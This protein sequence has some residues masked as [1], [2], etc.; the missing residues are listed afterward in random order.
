[1][2]QVGGGSTIGPKPPK[3]PKPKPQPQYGSEA[4]YTGS[5]QQQAAGNNR[6]TQ[7]RGTS[8]P[9]QSRTST[10]TE[11]SIAP[12]QQRRAGNNRVQRTVR[13]QS[14]PFNFYAVRGATQVATGKSMVGKPGYKNLNR[15]NTPTEARAAGVSIKQIRGTSPTGGRKST[16]GGAAGSSVVRSGGG[17]ASKGGSTFTGTTVKSGGGG[18]GKTTFGGGDGGKTSFGPPVGADPGARIGGGFKEFGTG[19]RGT[20]AFFDT[21]GGGG[22]GLSSGANPLA[23]SSSSFSNESLDEVL[24]G[25]KKKG[26]VKRARRTE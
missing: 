6:V 7:R 25:N 15:N 19:Y 18:G 2:P 20:P 4:S 13:S 26:R 16:Y 1:M 12:N 9:S 23:G 14:D 8:T 24:H 21:G 11:T 22:G 5:S 3:P 10:G 17:A